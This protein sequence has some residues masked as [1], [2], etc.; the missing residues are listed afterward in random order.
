VKDIQKKVDE[1][2]FSI[3]YFIIFINQFKKWTPTKIFFKRTRLRSAGTLTVNL[4]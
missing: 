2:T 4:S 3:V 1:F